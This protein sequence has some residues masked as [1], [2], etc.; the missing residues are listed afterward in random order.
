ML[1]FSEYQITQVLN[2]LHQ[3]FTMSDV[4]NAVEIWD[5]RHAEKILTAYLVTY[6]QVNISMI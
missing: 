2:N 3:I 6:C 5:K 4:Y 1:G